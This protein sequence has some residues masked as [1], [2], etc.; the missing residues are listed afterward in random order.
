VNVGDDPTHLWTSA[1]LNRKL[2]DVRLLIEKP[3]K[4]RKV[5]DEAEAPLLSYRELSQMIKAEWDGRKYSGEYLGQ[6]GEGVL[7]NQHR[8]SNKA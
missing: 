2:W 1:A 8:R 7:V 4:V 6:V 3:V 5:L